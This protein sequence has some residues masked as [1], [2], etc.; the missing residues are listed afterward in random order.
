MKA[1]T[2]C[3]RPFSSL[4]LGAGA[5]TSAKAEENQRASRAWRMP[6]AVWHVCDR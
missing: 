2:K 5:G 4:C 1:A 3:W 6:T